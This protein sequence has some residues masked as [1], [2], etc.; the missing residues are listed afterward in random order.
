MAIKRAEELS[1][2]TGDLTLTCRTL[3][4]RAWLRIREGEWD[5]AANLAAEAKAIAQEQLRSMFGTAFRVTVFE[6]RSPAGRRECRG[7]R[8]R[9]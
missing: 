4:S 5:R 6:R 1:R 2:R 8:K 7:S 9:W 3:T